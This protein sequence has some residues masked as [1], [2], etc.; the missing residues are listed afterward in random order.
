MNYYIRF[1]IAFLAFITGAESFAQTYCSPSYPNGCAVSNNRITNVAIGTINHAPP[2]CTVHDY[3]SI[4]TQIAAGIPTTLTVISAGWCGVGA[5]VDLNQDGDFDDPNEIMALPA[6][7]GVQV[8]TYVMTIT[9]PGATPDGNYRLRVYNR[10][11]NSGDGTPVNSPCGT[12]GY[13]SWDDY[14]LV[15]YHQCATITSTVANPSQLCTSGTTS[16]TCT[17]TSFSPATVKWYNESGTLVGTGSPFTTGTLN[18]TTTFYASVDNGTCDTPRVPVT[19]IVIPTVNTPLSITPT[20]TTICEGNIVTIHA[21]KNTINDSVIANQGTLTASKVPI[22]GTSTNSASEL[23]YT[24]DEL[25]TSGTITNI[26]FYKKSTNTTF[27]PGN[28][29]IYMKNTT[30]SAVTTTAS[31]TGYTLVYSGAWPNVGVAA[32]TWTSIVLNTPFE[33]L[34][35][36]NNLSIL[37][38]RPTATSS[39]LFAPTYRATSKA[40]SYKTS[41]YISTTAWSSGVSAMTLDTLRPDIKIGYQRL[42]NINWSPITALYKDIALTQAI[43]A[44]DTNSTV[45]AH[46]STTT[47]Y[48]AYGNLNGCLSTNYLS[49]NI[50]VKDTVHVLRNDSVCAGQSYTFGSQILT[51]SGVYSQSYQA[52]NFCD[53]VVI[54][55]FTVRPYITNTVAVSICQGSSYTFNGITYTTS[56]TGLK[57]TFAT[58]GCDSIVT[59][60]LTVTPNPVALAT[61]SPTSLCSGNSTA[62]NL[63]SSVAGTTYAWTVSQTN[64]SGATAGSG[65]SIAQALTATANTDGQVIYTITPT[66]SGCAGSAIK[67]T[68]TV[69]PKPAAIV[70]PA[71]QSICGGTAT[72][73]ALSSLVSG[74]TYSWTAAQTNTSGATT[75]TGTSIAQ[76]ITATTFTAGTATF[77][78]TPVANGCTGNTSTATITVNPVPAAPGAITGSATPCASSTQTYSV[79]GVSG[80]TSYIWS[81]PSG[82]TGTSTTNSI[83]V[84]VGANAGTIS[85][86]AVN[87][88]GNSV[89]TTK[90]VTPVPTVVPAITIVGNQPANL[91]SGASVTFTATTVNPGTTPAYQW[92]VNSSNVGTNSTT[93]TYTPLNGDTVRCQLSSNATCAT[94]VQVNS[95]GIIMNVLPLVSAALN[96]QVLENHICS[97]TAVVLL[98]T[99]TNGGATPGYQWRV[100]NVNVGTSNDTYSYFPVNG[101]IVTCI[102]TTSA[103]CTN[104][105]TVISNAVP[106]TIVQVTHPAINVTTSGPITGLTAGQTVTFTAVPTQAGAS[107]QV[108]WYKNDIYLNGALG[109]TFTGTFGTDIF[110]GTRIKA[111]LKSFSP[112]ASPDTAWSN[113]MIINQTP[114]GVGTINV[115]DGFSIYPNPTNGIVN[116]E[117]LQKDDQIILYDALGHKLMQKSVTHNGQNTL[118][119]SS[120]AQGMYQLFFI[121]DKGQ[122]WST[123]LVRQ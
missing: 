3:T 51:T 20:D 64:A 73:I 9:I 37:V 93:F 85:V 39:P 56:Q 111:K 30:A 57:D 17:Y 42:P 75:G 40:P 4:S 97:D 66:A 121:N 119:L 21:V 29:S 91:C 115:P 36:T 98:A 106:M 23:I 74:T 99:P 122:Q 87:A 89:A 32:N 41:Y 107:Y 105:P 59:L 62:I 34:G 112:C 113:V 5:A 81:L 48:H 70:T 72:S 43:A 12:Y 47:S 100:N 79:T 95:N 33:Y 117:G 14:T 94:L 110:K 10:T 63:T 22:N 118:D 109:N 44:T 49:S 82:W 24:S 2:G 120:F 67:D 18:T 65:S 86:T 31:L 38:V 13:G 1:A 46:P 7:N 26:G 25:N 53:S 90:A 52:A 58:S 108:T 77:T 76:T 35:G 116:I 45:Y 123:K 71:T 55:N 78:I 11:A 50:T 80:A 101:D 8:A 104:P 15:I 96:I 102:L 84:A 54:L 28:V 83:S 114:T 103:A 88:C 68:V 6:Y 61:P 16:L 27:N 19:V 69:K 92:T 60:N